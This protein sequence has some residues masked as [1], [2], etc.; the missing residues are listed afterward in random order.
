MKRVTVMCCALLCSL[1]ANAETM[2]ITR[3]KYAG[4][5]Q[6]A[7]PYAT[8]KTDVNGKEFDAKNLLDTYVSFSQLEQAPYINVT[9]I[10]AAAGSQAIAMLGFSL[11]NGRYAKGEIKVEGVEKYAVY[12]NGKKLSGEKLELIPAS[13]SIVVKYVASEGTPQ[14]T[15]ECPQDG[16]L[17]LREDGYR[18][19]TLQDVLH[20]T[21]FGGVSLSPDGKYLITN[22]S[23]ALPD[24]KSERSTTL[25]ELTTGNVSTPIGQGARWMPKS[26]LYYYTQTGAHGQKNIITVNPATGKESIFAANIP[27]GSFIIS[28][29]EDYL[30]YT[31]EQKGPQERD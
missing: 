30:L 17:S 20:G 4:P 25:T 16:I 13:H 18:D 5:H 7:T 8:D 3:F 11:Q 9:E 1:I 28:P 12:V 2:K 21:R 27:D 24:G 23:T 6:V 10:P 29:T 14:I 31:L 22:Y 15:V 26:S 19:Y